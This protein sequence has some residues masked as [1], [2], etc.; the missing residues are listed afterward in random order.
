MANRIGI[1]IS[2]EN[3]IIESR[4]QEIGSAEIRI[5]EFKY[6]GLPIEISISPKILHEGLKI[7]EGKMVELFMTNSQS[8]ILLKSDD[9]IKY[10][11]SPMV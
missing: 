4:E 1:K 9:G 2:K 5:K 11:M 7:S 10:I 6:D 3:F 8:S